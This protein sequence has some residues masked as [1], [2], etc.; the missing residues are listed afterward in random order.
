MFKMVI[1]VWEQVER[2]VEYYNDQGDVVSELVND[3]ILKD[4]ET[5]EST[6]NT[7]EEVVL[8]A[9]RQGLKPSDYEIYLEN[10]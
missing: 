3:Y 10:K 5:P 7:F 4:T 8:A 2:L 6:W 9:Q 1:Y